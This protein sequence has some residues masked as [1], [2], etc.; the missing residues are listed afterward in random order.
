M[1]ND[2]ILAFRA[3][4]Q[5]EKNASPHTIEAYQQDIAAFR[6]AV[7]QRQ[8][9]AWDEVTPWHV[10]A[11]L[12]HLHESGYSRRTVA[13]KLSALRAFF[14]FLHREGHVAHTPLEGVA[15]PKLEK[16]LPV[17][18]D[19]DEVTR[20]LALPDPAHPLGLRDRALL[21]TLYATGMRVSE[22]CSLD[23]TALDLSVG[24]VL[25]YGKGAKER[26]VL[27]GSHA[28]E[29][30]RRYLRDGRP[31]L[32]APGETR[33]FVNWRGGP[34]STRSVRRIVAKYVEQ[35]ALAKRVS[36]H[37][38]RHSFATH[39]LNAGAD[40]RTVQELLG[41]ASISSTQV[42]THVTRQRL[43]RVYDD[44]HPRA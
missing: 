39:L 14:R 13:R 18:L 33:L 30:L 43:R 5:I 9:L 40:L 7:L 8:N 11:Y 27:L 41:H 17:F 37:T 4:L 21:E 29:A 19:E 2:P 22:L 36:P 26:Y 31:K 1:Q 38:F 44:A 12:A 20:L 15:T 3:Y 25:V 24:T 32:A 6:E 28:T 35:A 42:Y 10:R 23:V 16:R 34:I